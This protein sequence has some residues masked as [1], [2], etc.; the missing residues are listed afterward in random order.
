MVSKSPALYALGKWL[1]GTGINTYIHDL[2]VEWIRD[3]NP[4]EFDDEESY[5]AEWRVG[6]K[7]KTG[8]DV[9]DVKIFEVSCEYPSFLLAQQCPQIIFVSSSLHFF[10]L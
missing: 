8:W 10:T 1:S 4:N 6:A 2:D 7:P 9:F 3:F 5:I